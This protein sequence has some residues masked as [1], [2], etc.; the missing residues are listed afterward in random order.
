MDEESDVVPS[1]TT[2]NGD[3]TI[4]STL[5]VGQSSTHQNPDANLSEQP[6]SS[7]TD[8]KTQEPKSLSDVV[9]RALKGETEAS[10]PSE[11]PKDPKSEADKPDPEKGGGKPGLE[12]VGEDGIPK[13]FHKH[14]AWQ[15]LKKE[16]DDARVE[17]EQY[18]G[19]SQEFRAITGFMQ[20]HNI[21]SEE[22]AETMTWLALRNTDPSKFATAIIN[23]ADQIRADMGMVLPPELQERVDAG[24]ISETDAK[25]WMK[26]QAEN[27]MLKT[28]SQRQ[29]EAHAER[30]QSEAVTRLA[31]QMQ[32]AVNTWE[33]EI[34][35][36]D[37][38]YGRK[39]QLVQRTMRSF[40]QEYGWPKSAE[41]ALKYAKVA[42]DQVTK[43]LNGMLPPRKENNPKTPEG[44]QV[45]TDFKPNSL[46]DVVSHVLQGGV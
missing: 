28:Q 9:E 27:R 26:T 37:L 45:E 1:T 13:E 8:A 15:R 42:H 36:V 5:D 12:D 38:D 3:T 20:Q 33:K 7:E 17:I 31:K 32:D 10:S 11:Q 16:R 25:A 22:V 35:K 29:T 24:E 21:T 39:R 2:Q 19:D 18:R 30:E 40:I 14:P 23:L 4:D 46:E 34:Q 41:Q 44:K 43:E 6:S